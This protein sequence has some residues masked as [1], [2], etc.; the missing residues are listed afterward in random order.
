M[1][2]AIAF[3]DRAGLRAWLDAHHASAR[4]L[5]VLVARAG[6]G[7]PSVTWEDCVVEALRAGWIDG[8]KRSAGPGSSGSRPA[9]GAPPGPNG[10]GGTP[11]G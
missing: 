8:V 4:Q 2:D 10:T 7:V 1:D 3:A 5:L 9:A 11:S 6:T